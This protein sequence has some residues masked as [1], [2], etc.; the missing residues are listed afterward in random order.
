MLAAGTRYIWVVRLMGPQRVEVH[1]K[2]APMRILSATD[3]LEAPGILRNPVPVQALFDRKEANR[4]TLRNLLQREG[5][6]DLEA[7][8]REGREE[9]REIGRKAGLQEG[10]RKGEMKGK[11]EGRKEKA[12]E[13]A[14]VALAKGM[15]VGL[16]AEISGLSEAEVRGL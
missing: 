3:T 10:E 11:E 4:V 2:D 14:R 7:V 16:V 1:T 12:V 9:G 8:L 6:E 13:I 5:Y 15:E